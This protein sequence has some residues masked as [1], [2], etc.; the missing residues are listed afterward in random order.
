MRVMFPMRQKV[1]ALQYKDASLDDRDSCVRERYVAL[2]TAEDHDRA[3]QD[4]T[5]R[6]DAVE[7][8]LK[9]CLNELASLTKLV[10]AGGAHFSS[11]KAVT[12]KTRREIEGTFKGDLA[13]FRK[14]FLD[15]ATVEL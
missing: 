6:H 10:N 1:A 5:A 3:Y 12:F 7:V 4:L 2:A 11:G 9:I 8:Q 13:D 15:Q 14:S